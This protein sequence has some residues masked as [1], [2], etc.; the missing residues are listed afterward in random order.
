MF[1]YV[2]KQLNKVSN[3]EPEKNVIYFEIKSGL[4]ILYF[5]R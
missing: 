5:R 2:F 4:Q 3:S 1:I